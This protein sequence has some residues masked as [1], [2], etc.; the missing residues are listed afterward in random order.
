M[1]TFSI[2]YI[3]AFR[4]YTV[5]ESITQS[6]QNKFLMVFRRV[7]EERIPAD[8]PVEITNLTLTEDQH[9][10]ITLSSLKKDDLTFALTMCKEITGELHDLTTIT[11]IPQQN[12]ASSSLTYRGFLRSV[13]SVGFGIFV[14]IGFINPRKD[15][16]IPLHTLRKQLVN[17]S[18]LSLHDITTLYGFLDYLPVEIQLT[19]LMKDIKNAIKVE[20]EFSTPFLQQIKTWVNDQH[21]IIFSTGVPRQLV[22]KTIAKRGH[23]IDILSISRLGPLETA[24]ICKSGTTGPGIISRI[25]PYTILAITSLT[26]TFTFKYA[27]FDSYSRS[28]I[29][30]FGFPFSY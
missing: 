10:Q 14:D 2:E 11:Q 13:S 23:T 17:N 22:K 15:V 27:V 29:S 24:I 9:V 5:T 1:R 8:L 12:P 6:M 3:T 21:E 26:M 30:I 7:L 25:G 20:G 16:L 28:E 18:I 4:Y 19:S